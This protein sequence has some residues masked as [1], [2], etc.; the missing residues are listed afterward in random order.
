[1]IVTIHQPEHM[2]W[3]GYFAKMA[4]A[5]LYVVCDQVQYR[6]QY[7]QNRNRIPGVQ[8]PIWLN[9][10]V[11]R[12]GMSHL[13]IHAVAI[14]N[15][16]DWRKPY[17]GAIAYQY[18]KHPHYARY[19]EPLRA[20]V[21]APWQRLIDFNLALIG[22][23]R[24]E[25]GIETPMVLAS[26]LGASGQKTEMIHHV[27]LRTGATTYLSG[28]SGRDYLDEAPFRHAG[29][30]VAYHAFEHP[31][32]AQHGRADFTP[33]MAA[34]D[35]LMNAGPDA[36]RV[37]LGDRPAPRRKP[38]PLVPSGSASWRSASDPDA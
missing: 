10:P 3:L 19:A 35:L 20:I 36:R 23:F 17:W 38:A 7:F 5:D 27:C 33:N 21:E 24:T 12:R 34:L 37:L 29:I 18:R 8:D 32:Y 30:A 14:D 15:S 28:P 6:H 9:V 25:L 2:P 16:R 4:D 22:F 1:M 13:P 11:L 31:R 26:E